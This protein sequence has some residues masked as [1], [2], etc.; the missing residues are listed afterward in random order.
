MVRNFLNEVLNVEHGIEGIDFQRDKAFGKALEEE[1]SKL[2]E[3]KKVTTK[4]IAA[5]NMAAIISE[6]T[7]FKKVYVISEEGVRNNAG[8]KPLNIQPTHPLYNPYYQYL[9]H[10]VP[11][12]EVIKKTNRLTGLIDLKDGKV[13]GDF[14]D[15]EQTF[16]IAQNL[17]SQNSPLKPDE[18]TAM[19]LH[20][21]GHTVTILEYFARVTRTN[22]LLEEGV[23]QLMGAET[24]QQKLELIVDIE[25]AIG[26]KLGDH[27]YL[28]KEGVSEDAYRTLI[29]SASISASIDQL[30]DNIYNYRMCEMVA[31]QYAIRQGYGVPHARGLDKLFPGMERSSDVVRG[32]SRFA[33]IAGIVGWTAL[34][35][36]VG[37]LLFFQGDMR[38]KIYPSPKERLEAVVNE[39]TAALKDKKLT[40]EQK[41]VYLQEIEEVEKILKN[42]RTYRSTLTLLHDYIIPRG[43]NH[44]KT[45][46]L[47]QMLEKL[48]NNP[49]FRAAAALDVANV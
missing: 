34:T 1:I 38:A 35:L 9:A 48:H 44:Y 17:I 12:H 6:H 18:L 20:E 36:G 46:K 26:K 15:L 32:M 23:R 42:Y 33:E 10:Q 25:D 47:Q 27:N 31:D 2:M 5:S 14:Q 37:V 3:K 16:F 28:T 11:I 45:E 7:G 49:M 22:Y 21:V 29:V 40:N 39:L 43:R 24:K 19:L 30:G 4:D 8:A 41:K 13:Y